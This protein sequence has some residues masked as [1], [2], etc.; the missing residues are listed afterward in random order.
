MYME[1]LHMSGETSLKQIF[2][3]VD[4]V[5]LRE[6]HGGMF[7][8]P[9]HLT[10]RLR[11]TSIDSLELG[12]R[13]YHSLKRAGI[14]NIGALAESIADGKSLKNIRNCGAK[15]VREIM[16]KLFLYQYHS[17]KPERRDDYLAEVVVMNAMAKGQ[18]EAE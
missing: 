16:E 12:V 4:G 5:H 14:E 1:A 11:E 10:Q 3:G 8:Y 2:D 17:L 9:L 7:R 6:K 15:S 13:A 18:I